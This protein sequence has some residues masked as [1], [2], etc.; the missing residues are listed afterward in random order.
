[1]S[2]GKKTKILLILIVLIIATSAVL[3]A[4]RFRQPAALAG[5]PAAPQTAEAANG[6]ISVSVQAISTAEPAALLSLRNRQSGSIKSVLPVGS[7]VQS[8]ETVA[9]MDDSDQRKS[10]AQAELALQLARINLERAQASE[11]RAK[12]ELDARLALFAAKAATQDQVESARDALAS[13]EFSRRSAALSTEQA[14]LNLEQAR[15]DLADTIIRAP[16][17]GVITRAATA[18]DIVPSNSQVAVLADVSRLLFQAEVDEY[19]I[20]KLRAN[21]PATVSVPALGNQE[22]RARVEVISPT[23]EIVSNIS[24]FKVSVFVDNTEGLLRP[25]MSADLSFT[26]SNDR[27]IIIPVRAVTTVRGRTYVDVHNGEAEPETRRIETGA[28]DSRNIIVLEGLS[29]GEKVILP[30]APVPVTT[31]AA[32]TSSGTSIIPISVPGTGGGNR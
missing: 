3:L 31:T 29:A 9:V 6:T 26:V 20:G 8:G 17:G 18:G 25:G 4:M 1:M 11:T 5:Q 23:A 15:K 30:G 2:K 21:M 7:R 13:A 19:D 27:G 32:K 22:F 10:L 12:S 24:I 14:S 16:F 28:S